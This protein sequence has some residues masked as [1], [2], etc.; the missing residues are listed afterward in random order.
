MTPGPMVEWVG[1]AFIQGS[2][3]YGIISVD[4]R[5]SEFTVPVLTASVECTELSPITGYAI[6][7]MEHVMFA[8]V[9]PDSIENW[10]WVNL[11]QVG[12]WV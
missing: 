7:P 11:D 3:L 10:T 1:S 5:R 12:W 6:E 2:T 9:S 4:V 8:P